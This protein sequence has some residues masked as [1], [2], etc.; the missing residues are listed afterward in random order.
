MKK[1]SLEIVNPALRHPLAVLSWMLAAACYTYIPV[2]I[3]APPSGSAVRVKLNGTGTS[4]VAPRFGPGV[5]AVDGTLSSIA[6]DGALAMS[7]TA[8]Q[9]AIGAR[10]DLLVDDTITLSRSY[11]AGLELRTLNRRKTTIAA[12]AIAAS[13]ATVGVIVMR[14]SRAD[15]AANE[16]SPGPLTARAPAWIWTR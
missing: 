2:S 14:G 13:I 1:R 12:V 16:P 11:V 9:P 10:Q 15:A 3:T 7:A 6:A 8:L 4:A 5:M